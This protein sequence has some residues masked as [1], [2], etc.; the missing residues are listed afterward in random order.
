MRQTLTAEQYIAG[1]RNAA[2][3]TY[4]RRYLAWV[5]SGRAGHN[6]PE[7]DRSALSYMAAQAVRME[8][9]GFIPVDSEPIEAGF[10]ESL[11]TRVTRFCDRKGF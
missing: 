10:P 4:A 7:W 9:D 8:I 6:G 11:L 5:R 3:K 2:K 1:I